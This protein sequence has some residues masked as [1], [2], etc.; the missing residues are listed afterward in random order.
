MR[1]SKG[2]CCALLAAA[3]MAPVSAKAETILIFFDWGRTNLT[4]LAGKIVKSARGLIGPSSTVTIT[5]HSDG[6]E[7]VAL[8]EKRAAAV[9]AALIRAGAPKTATLTA[10]ARGAEAPLVQATTPD[11]REP[12]NRRVQIDIP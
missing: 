8:S 10:V 7:P 1:F 12:Q 9:R 5:G 4:P 3:A 2:L 6:S 11:G